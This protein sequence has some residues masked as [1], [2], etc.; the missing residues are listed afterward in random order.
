MG[1]MKMIFIIFVCFA[2]LAGLYLYATNKIGNPFL[3]NLENQSKDNSKSDCP[4][5]LIRKGN[6]LLL[7]N[8]KEPESETNPIPFY[9]L[10]EYIYYLEIQRKKGANCPV[11]YLQQENNTQGENVYRIRPSPFQLEPGL[12]QTTSVDQQNPSAIPIL[13]ANRDHPP[14]NENNYPGFDSHGLYV[15]KYTQI[16]KVHDTTQ[17]MPLSDNPMDPNWGGVLHT[18]KAVDS[19]KYAENNVTVP[20]LFQPKNTTFIPGLFNQPPPK[21]ML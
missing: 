14:Y 21:D 3:E 15:G 1:K 2:F 5:L 18:Q 16:D 10:D 17:N 12:P 4:D 11:L 7:Y 13:D 9:N 19:G 8:S 6:I 20:R